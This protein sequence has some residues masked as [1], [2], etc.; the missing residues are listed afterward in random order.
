MTEYLSLLNVKS[1]EA[2]VFNSF[3]ELNF[4]VFAV[5]VSL[6]LI[7]ILFRVLLGLR[8]MA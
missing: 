5:I 6:F 4:K 2:D 1:Y 7:F 3:E 8:L